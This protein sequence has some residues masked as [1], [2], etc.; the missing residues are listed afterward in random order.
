MR[1]GDA[2]SCSAAYS[3]TVSSI[4]HRDQVPKHVAVGA[5]ASAARLALDLR[6]VE[7][8]RPWAEEAEKL[9]RSSGDGEGL[10][11]SLHCLGQAAAIEG[12]HAEARVRLLESSRLFG[13]LGLTAPAAGRLTYLAD[14]EW[15]SGD[16]EA[17]RAA[18]ERAAELYAAAGDRFGVAS[19]RHGC[20]DLAL[21]QG[22]DV[23]ARVLYAEALEAMVDSGSD[24]DLAYCFGGLAAVAAR[25]GRL[26]DAGRLWGAVERI[27]GELGQA[28]NETERAVYTTS[29][30]DRRRADVAAGRSLSTAEAVDLARSV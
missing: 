22:D 6:D 8:G 27:E 24:G 17:A 21:D 20:G 5:L 29:L 11:W 28:L 23:S 25:G 15:R 7:R 13:V 12:D 18:L 3:R 9:A 19:C 1:S 14:L 4:V 26:A 16:H 30:G 2:A 10:A